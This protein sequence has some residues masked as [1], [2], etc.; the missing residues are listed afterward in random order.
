MVKLH[1]GVFARLGLVTRMSGVKVWPRVLLEA[2]PL[3]LSTLANA[4]QTQ[5]WPIREPVCKHG[6]L[7][8]NFAPRRR[9][10][11]NATFLP[12]WIFANW[13]FLGLARLQL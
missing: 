3:S 10:Q 1:R 2:R 13:Q 8:L 12:E 11:E 6:I 7:C 5:K 4:N 9:I